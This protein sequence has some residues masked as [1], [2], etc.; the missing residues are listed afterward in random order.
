MFSFLI[1][2]PFKEIP[3]SMKIFSTIAFL[4]CLPGRESYAQVKI[5]LPV[6]AAQISSVLDLSNL[7]DPAKGL[8][9]PRITN[10][11]R[12]TTPINGKLV[13]DLS[14]NCTKVYD[15]D[16]WSSCLFT[17]PSAATVNCTASTLDGNYYQ[18]TALTI[19]N[20]VTIL[21]NNSS[22]T[23]LTIYITTGN[24]NFNS[25]DAA[26]L[27]GTY[28]AEIIKYQLKSTAIKKW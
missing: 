15:N 6:G 28:N 14:S 23:A 20:T 9:L 24:I 10:T 19:S 18:H 4:T 5:G 27:S 26:A 13:Y 8:V 11:A 3:I 12:V 2:K 7:G 22:S 17:P 21:V 16:A 1:D 25:G